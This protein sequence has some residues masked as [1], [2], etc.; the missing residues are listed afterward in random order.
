MGFDITT[1]LYDPTRKVNKLKFIK[2]EINGTEYS[3]WSEVPYIINF[4]LYLFTR[5]VTDTLQIVEQ[6]LPN[7]APDFT[8]SLNMNNLS[9]IVDVPIVLNSVATNE[10]FEGDFATRRLITSVFDFTAKTYVYGQ[11]KERTPVAIETS[12]VNFF[13]SLIGSTAAP[14]NFITDFGWTG[15]AATGSITMTDGSSVI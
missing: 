10:D 9:S 14:S 5:N 3:M 11:I 4:N 12:E 6:I 1:Y 2:K 8:V 7:F 13:N 15:N